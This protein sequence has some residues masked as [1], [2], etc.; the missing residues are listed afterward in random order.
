MEKL[1]RRD[2]VKRVLAGIT[3]LASET[4]SLPAFP[5]GKESTGLPPAGDFWKQVDAVQGR[6]LVASAIAAARAQIESQ[7]AM[8]MS[9]RAAV[10]LG[11]SAVQEH[12]KRAEERFQARTAA[13]EKTKQA[14][15][16]F[17]KHAGS[18]GE[19]RFADFM[20]KGGLK[21]LAAHARESSLHALLNSDV[22]PQ[23]AQSAVKAL[24]DRLAAIQQLSSFRDAV[25]RL[26]QHLD[27]LIT[28]KMPAD[29]PNGLCVLILLITSIFMVLLIVALLICIFSLGF[30][31]KGVLDNLLA[32]AC[33]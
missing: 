18:S 30:A 6:D 20:H 25:S 27:D 19:R 5:Q 11:P 21:E 31:C 8:N 23:E 13:L 12:V 7:R 14:L 9:Q 28:R 32:Q 15:A 33:P 16:Q 26:D 24:D 2:C 17:V 10:L 22:S 4:V 1:D 3:I 29:D